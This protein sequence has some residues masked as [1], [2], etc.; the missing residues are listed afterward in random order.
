M[1]L[2]LGYFHWTRGIKPFQAE[3]FCQTPVLGLRLGVDFIFAGDNH[4]QNNSNPHLNFVKGTVLGDKEQG[5]GIRDKGYG[6][7]NNG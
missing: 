5:V 4:N 3:H 2:G 7:R 1:G 6:I